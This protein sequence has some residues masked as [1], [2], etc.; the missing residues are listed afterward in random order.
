MSCYVTFVYYPFEVQDVVDVD[1][2]STSKHD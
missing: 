2:A 1:A